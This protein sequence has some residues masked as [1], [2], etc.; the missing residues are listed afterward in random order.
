[1]PSSFIIR[2]N[3]LENNKNYI[4]MTLFQPI[5]WLNALCSF[6]EGRVGNGEITGQGVSLRYIK[7]Y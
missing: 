2:K 3:A 5:K 6:G 4:K 7:S 1:M